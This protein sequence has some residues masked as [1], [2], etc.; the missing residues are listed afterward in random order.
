MLLAFGVPLRLAELWSWSQKLKDATMLPKAQMLIRADRE[1]LT[2]GATSV[3]WRDVRLEAVELRY[4]WRLR[5]FPKYRIDQLHLA[6]G[7]GPL[8]LDVRLI[9]NGREVLDTICGKLVCR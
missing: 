1:Y 2:V 5:L 9:E 6:T 7:N 8:V 3:P 4:L